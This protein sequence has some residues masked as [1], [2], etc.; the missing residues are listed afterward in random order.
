MKWVWT[1]SLPSYSAISPISELLFNCCSI[2]ADGTCFGPHR[3]MQWWRAVKRRFAVKRAEFTRSDEAKSA[4][5]DKTS[6]PLAKT[7]VYSFGP[8][9]VN[10]QAVCHAGHLSFGDGRKG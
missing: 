1:A 9:V 5:P 10:Q 7:M 4:M 2:G 8:V 3:T 6:S